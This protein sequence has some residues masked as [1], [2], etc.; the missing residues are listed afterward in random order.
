MTKYKEIKI[1]V[2]VAPEVIINE[3]LKKMTEQNKK[4][5][6]DNKE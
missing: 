5:N 3:M 1:D 6:D 2:K 4:Q